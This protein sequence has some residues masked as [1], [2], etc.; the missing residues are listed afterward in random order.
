MT[1]F[2]AIIKDD[3]EMLIDNKVKYCQ[4]MWEDDRFF[5]SKTSYCKQLVDILNIDV[6]CYERKYLRG[7]LNIFGYI[8]EN[9]G[10]LQM[11]KN[12]TLEWSGTNRFSR[13]DD[14]Q[15]R[16]LFFK[17]LLLQTLDFK[18]FCELFH[19]QEYLRKLISNC[20]LA[21]KIYSFTYQST[22][23]EKI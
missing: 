9:V 4:K 15:K 5:D 1:C 17:T 12:F 13:L 21:A 8:Q 14:Q 6:S 11:L 19:Y 3:G 20:R 2:G 16:I 18:K 22:S 7:F 23:V 10:K